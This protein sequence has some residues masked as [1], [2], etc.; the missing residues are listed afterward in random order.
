[1]MAK[2]E[3]RLWHG[4]SSGLSRKDRKPCEYQVYIPDNL[5]GRTFSLEGGVSADVVDAESALV[6]FN[7]DAASLVNTEALARILLRAESVASSKIEGL[8]IGARRILRAEVENS[9]NGSAT[10]VTAVEVLANIQA[11]VYGIERIVEDQQITLELILSIHERLLAGTGL[12]KYGGKLRDEQNWIGGSDFNPCSASYVP[13]PWELVKGLMEDLITFCNSDDLPAVVQAAIAHAQFETIHPFIDGNGRTGRI[14]I[15]LILRR[16][17]LSTRV[18]PPISLILATWTQDYVA[19]LTATRY[20]GDRLSVEALEGMNI[21]VGRFAACYRSVLDAMEFE[22]RARRIENEWRSRLKK[23][24]RDSSA[25]LLLQKLVGVP[26]LTIKSASMLI[27]RTE[28]ATATAIKQLMEAGILHQVGMGGRNRAFEAP[29]IIEAFHDL[30]RQLASPEG[31][32]H[33]SKPTRHVPAR[34]KKI[35]QDD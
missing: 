35:N 32:T 25:D 3:R 15:Q 5:T 20:I 19:G 21:W 24:R 14:L 17:G 1:M 11:M 28:V 26:V 22:A 29:E 23:V 30:E 31:D 16:R 7:T 12:S 10:D 6:R 4:D 34:I 2:V 9:L 33:K 13:P 8:V 27:G 18:S